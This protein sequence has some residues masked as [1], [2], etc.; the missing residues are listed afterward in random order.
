MYRQCYRLA[1]APLFSSAFRRPQRGVLNGVPRVRA[2]PFSVSAPTD[3]S[4]TLFQDLGAEV[5]G[6]N[7]RVG[8]PGPSELAKCA[9]MLRQAAAWK[10]SQEDVDS[11]FHYGPQKGDPGFRRAL[12]TFLS[13]RYGDEVLADELIPTAGATQGLAMLTSFYFSTGDVV[14]VEDLTF[15][16]AL[17]FFRKELNLKVISIR[18]DSEGIIPSEL[19]RRVDEYSSELRTPGDER[20]FRAMLYCIPTYHNPTG[21]CLSPERRSELVRVARECE[22]LVACDDVYNL[23]PIS[24]SDDQPV[25]MSQRLLAYDDIAPGDKTSGNVVS[26]GTF[27]KIFGPGVRLGWLEGPD[28]I[29]EPLR[30]SHFIRGGGAV[31]HVVAGLAEGLI[32][33]GLLGRHVDHCQSVFQTRARVLDAALRKHLPAGCS[34]VFPEG[35]FFIW[36]RLPENVDGGELETSV[37]QDNVLIFSG[38]NFSPDGKFNNYVRLCFTY[39]EEEQLSQGAEIIGKHVRVLAESN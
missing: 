28:R 9:D 24:P 16:I 11:L 21:R 1:S 3:G 35:G 10:M 5:D 36:L 20:P 37:L 30:T 34:W 38:R 32:V 27:S 33:L 25:K 19:K 15:F 4:A 6:P 31:Q 39:S 29:L 22:L 17:E 13:S 2:A 8:S 18:S 26:N 23:L 12:A 7:L 14:F